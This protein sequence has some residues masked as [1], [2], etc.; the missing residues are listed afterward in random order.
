MAKLDQFIQL[1]HQRQAQSIKL[2][3]GQQVRLTVG[4]TSNPM[5]KNAVSESQVLSLVKEIAPPDVPAGYRPR[6]RCASPTPLPPAP[7]RSSC[8]PKAAR[9]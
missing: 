2:A 3:G 7:C 1:L 9:R 6:P 5:T 4:G 8:A